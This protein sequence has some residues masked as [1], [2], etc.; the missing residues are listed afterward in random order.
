MDVWTNA[1]FMDLIAKYNCVWLSFCLY[2][3]QFCILCKCKTIGKIG[4]SLVE[5]LV[6]HQAM[7]ICC[8]FLSLAITEPCRFSTTYFSRLLCQRPCLPYQLYET[9]IWENV[10]TVFNAFISF[11]MGCSEKIML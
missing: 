4:Y 5:P 7:D 3:C 2:F 11:F 1:K 9:Y 8:I 6:C 10:L